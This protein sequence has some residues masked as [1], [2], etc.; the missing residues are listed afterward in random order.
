[1]YALASIDFSDQLGFVVSKLPPEEIDT[2]DQTVETKRSL[3]TSALEDQ[4]VETKRS[5]PT[6]ALEDQTVETKR[7]LPTSAL[8]E[9][10]FGAA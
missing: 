1:M 7:S 4:T 10:V 6:S 3:P 2:R 5:L 9:A 8:E